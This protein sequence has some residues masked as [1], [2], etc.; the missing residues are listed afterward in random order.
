MTEPTNNNSGSGKNLNDLF[1]ESIGQQEFSPSP[2]VWRNL[3]WKLL[4]RELKQFNF[5]NIPKLALVSVSTGLVIIASLTYWVLQP[6]GYHTPATGPETHAPVVI[7]PSTQKSIPVKP[8]EKP[9]TLTEKP[10]AQYPAGANPVHSTGMTAKRNLNAVTLIASNT[11]VE[12]TLTVTATPVNAET[13]AGSVATREEPATKQFSNTG[14]QPL[15]PLVFSN[16]ETWPSTD[17]LS[18]IRSGE[19]FKYVRDKIPVS[20]FFS[21]NLDIA[22]EMAL[23]RSNGSTNQEFNYWVNAEIAYHFSRFSVHTGL[24]LGYTYDEGI[25]K[26]QYRSNDSVSFYKEVIGYYTDPANPAKIIYITR[27][28]AIY[29]SITHMADDR[30]RNRYTY[31]QIPLLLG[32]DVFETRRFCLGIEAGP[33][34]S[35]LINE[36]KAE[37]SINIPDGRLILLQDNTP[38][39]QPTNWQLWVRLSIGYQF[40]KNWGLVISPYY[41]YFLTSPVQSSESGTPTTQ[42]IGLD[43]GIQY[44]FGRKINKK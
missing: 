33:A 41:K 39:R 38:P 36:R 12:N 3:N 2:K 32:Y 9:V 22:P 25:Y 34:F 30:T 7:Q 13:P 27:N 37:P 29:D 19:V 43:V 20:S 23:Y 14:I 15:V 42:A 40:T 8:E 35:F 26:M 5:I 17:T 10:S 1:R 18:F 4:I 11:V 16:F 31:L 28:H 6:G 24:G 21:A 44:L